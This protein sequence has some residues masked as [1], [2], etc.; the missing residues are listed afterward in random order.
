MGELKPSENYPG[1]YDIDGY[2]NYAI[3]RS[4]EVINKSSGRPLRGSTNPS[5]YLN[6]RIT[7]DKRY[8]KTWGRHRLLGFV[9]K[10]PDIPIDKLVINHLDG[11][12]GHDVLSNLEWTTYQG[13]IEHAGASGYTEKCIP[14]S[15]R[16][17]TTGV[18]TKYPSVKKCALDLGLSK[19]AVLWRIRCG[20]MRVF[21][22]GKQYRK[23]HAD[24]PWHNPTRRDIYHGRAKRVAVRYLETGHIVEYDRLSDVSELL[25]VKLPT[26]STRINNPRQPIVG[27]LVQLQW[28]DEVKEWR[29]IEDI[30]LDLDEVTGSRSVVIIDNTTGERT[31]F[32]SAAECSKSL[33]IVKSTLHARLKS[34][35]KR[36]IDGYRFAYY[37]DI[38]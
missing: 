13:N 31:I 27:G 14:I 11:I 38:I 28:A 23:S 2:S 4:G 18:V 24:M 17:I 30:R 29:H 7:D 19:D 25:N 20:E 12:K 6:Y 26:L 36:V 33:G 21:P 16:D 32:N 1:Y 9:F 3:S 15:V 8:T 22:E 5:G 37:S 34:K 35:G 10:K